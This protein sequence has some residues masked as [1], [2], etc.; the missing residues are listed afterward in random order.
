MEHEHARRLQCTRGGR[1]TPSV[2]PGRS[3]R[4][5]ASAG[6]NA[7]DRGRVATATWRRAA[8]GR[9]CRRR[10]SA[11]C[12]PA[13]ERCRARSCPCQCT[14]CPHAPRRCARQNG[15]RRLDALCALVA[16][17]SR[18]RP[19]CSARREHDQRR[20][21]REPTRQRSVCAWE[22]GVRHYGE[23]ARGRKPAESTPPDPLL[24][25]WG[26]SHVP[27]MFDV[28]FSWPPSPT[29]APCPHVGQGPLVNSTRIGQDFRRS[30]GIRERQ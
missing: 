14:G 4:R 21:Q 15:V 10:S 2:K 9:S 24:N 19:R 25:H 7:C 13:L 11:G 16:H 29:L 3:V 12:A 18:R 28:S 23:P 6:W 27:G 20:K 5:T 1:K 8:R 22:N 17:R 30:A 26:V